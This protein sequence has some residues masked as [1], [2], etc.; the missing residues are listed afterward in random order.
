VDEADYPRLLPP[1]GFDPSTL[2]V[3]AVPT[4]DWAAEGFDGIC[5]VSA[6]RVR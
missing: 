4:Q 3:R 2:V 6:E 5:C 1:L